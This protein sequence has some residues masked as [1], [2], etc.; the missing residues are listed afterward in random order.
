[1]VSRDWEEMDIETEWNND[2]KDRF[3][4]VQIKKMGVVG[5]FTWVLL[6]LLGYYLV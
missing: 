4:C 3:F 5:G 6:V 1:L 2:E